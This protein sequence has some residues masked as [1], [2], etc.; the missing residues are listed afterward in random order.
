MEIV[1]LT[2]YLLNSLLGLFSLNIVYKHKIRIYILI[3]INYL[4]VA[5]LGLSFLAEEY[6]IEGLLSLAL[7]GL[8]FVLTNK[9]LPKFITKDVNAL[10]KLSFIPVISLWFIFFL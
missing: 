2:I 10:M 4:V 8:P 7:F 9:T 3:G 1:G 6:I 5:V